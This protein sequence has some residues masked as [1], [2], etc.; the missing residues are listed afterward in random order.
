MVRLVFAVVLVVLVSSQSRAAREWPASMSVGEADAA[1][2]T[3]RR[4]HR[5]CTRPRWMMALVATS[6]LMVSLVACS[7]REEQAPA[8][9][10]R[11]EKDTVVFDPGSPQIASIQTAAVEL[12]RDASLQLHGRLVWNED[13]T[14]RVF[15][16]IAG[17]VIVIYARV[18]DHVGAGQ[19]LATL[20]APEVGVAQSEASKAEQDFILAQKNLTRVEELQAVGALPLKDL[21]A[22]QADLVRASTERTRTRARL[23]TYGTDGA[24]DQR[25]VLRSAIAGVVVERNLNP[26]QEARPDANPERP[27]FV[28]SDPR[29][30][31]F[32][33]DIGEGDLA[34]VTP[35]AAVRI[36][37][38]ALGA[39]HGMGR[40]A[41]VADL[42]DPQTRT[43]K[44]QGIV[45]NVDRRLKAEMFI[46][47]EL[48]V[49]SPRGLFVPAR[50]VYLHGDRNYVFID[51][52]G[53]RYVRRPVTVGP[54]DGDR[55]LVLDGVTPADRIVVD[56]VLL[57]DKILAAGD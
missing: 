33:L 16:P 1:A 47:G 9:S 11:V 28:I 40:V 14:V 8:R 46:T 38:T 29:Q 45:D 41:H 12:P 48:K 3:R 17:R 50:S 22:A 25:F 42:V 32:L 39:E 56:G 43:V 6:V 15:S 57:L 21:Q 51:A 13:R 4:A 7:R 5:E 23:R 30:L 53:G 18:G 31:W 2:L 54:R 26:G 52:G 44:V 10:P 35:G 55:Q 49:P 34:A 19:T 37:A 27:Y 24:V 20:E 36:T